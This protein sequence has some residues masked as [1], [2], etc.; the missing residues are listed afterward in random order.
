MIDRFDDGDAAKA[1]EKLA[2]VFDDSSVAVSV[3]DPSEPDCPLV[4][5]N[6]AFTDLTGYQPRDALGRNCRFLQGPATAP[7]PVA[8]A[9]RAI[10]TRAAA[11]FCLKNY[12]RDGEPF[13]NLLFMTPLSSLDGVDLI[14]GCQ[15]TLRADVQFD[16]FAVYSREVNSAIEGASI[17]WRDAYGT[18]LEAMRLRADACARSA[19]AWLRSVRPASLE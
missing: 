13:Q 3:G 5:V 14:F 2:P 1:I 15:F 8:A 17:S 6:A 11:S 10:E 9:R 16:D 12:R 7:E 4:Y 19:R 18:H